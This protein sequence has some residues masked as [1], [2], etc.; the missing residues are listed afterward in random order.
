MIHAD[1][2]TVLYCVVYGK[3]LYFVALP[4]PNLLTHTSVQ[5]LVG[6]YRFVSVCVCLCML[7]TVLVLCVYLCLS[8]FVCATLFVYVL[9]LFVCVY[10]F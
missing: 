9:C 1:I 2:S 5:Y 8:V 4:K 3:V 6:L 10:V 7:V